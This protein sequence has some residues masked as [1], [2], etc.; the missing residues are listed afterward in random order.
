MSQTSWECINHE[1]ALLYCN[2]LSYVDIGSHMR[3]KVLRTRI[4][5]WTGRVGKERSAFDG[6][7]TG[8]KARKRGRV[9]TGER[10]SIG[11]RA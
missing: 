4:V 1:Y 3:C 8:G 9:S 5:C 11:K 6:E 2:L 7:D 10:S